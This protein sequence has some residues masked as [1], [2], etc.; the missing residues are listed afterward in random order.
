MEH[1]INEFIV[2]NNKG[3]IIQLKVTPTI[4]NTCRDCFFY[5]H[6]NVCS[7]IR[8]IIGICD[9]I[10]RTDNTPVIF[11][12]I[13]NKIMKNITLEEARKLYKQG[14]MAKEI[15]L[16]TY[17]EE[18]IVNDYTLITSLP[19]ETT[20]KTTELY[21]KLKTVY[22]E[23][24]KDKEVN[25]TKFNLYTPTI[26]FSSNNLKPYSGEF[27]SKVLID[28]IE[29]SIYISTNNTIFKGKLGYTNDGIY[30]GS[31][32]LENTWTFKEREQ[33]Y[34]FVKCFYKELILLS[35]ADEHKVEFI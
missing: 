8:N 19:E 32:L 27:V 20:C 3:E 10:D 34:H 1:K 17:K 15:A 33:A 21:A 22:K 26:T 24:S 13:N 4:D 35:L 11:K 28:D 29:F 16:R 12:R 5:G 30:C 31:R 7:D 2:Y 6:Y 9:K 23:I 18:E 25:L 14:G